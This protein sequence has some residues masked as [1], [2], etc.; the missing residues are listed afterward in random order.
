MT[1][2][3]TY[4]EH[5]LGVLSQVTQALETGAEGD[6]RRGLHRLHADTLSALRQAQAGQVDPNEPW[7][8]CR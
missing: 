8:G 7:G 1:T 4:N 2:P 3:I 6:R 5:L